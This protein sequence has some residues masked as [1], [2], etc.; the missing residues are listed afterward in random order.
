MQSETFVLVPS[1][2]HARYIE[3]CLRSIFDQ[4]LPPKKLLVIDD[5]S[6]DGSVDVIRRV[7]ADCP[8]AS[9]L[10]AR[11]NRGLCRTLNEGIAK[12][13]GEYF[14]YLGSDDRWMPG[15][16]AARTRLL[17][18]CRNAVL[19]YGNALLVDAEGDI[20]Y[21]TAD[22]NEVKYPDGNPSS[23]LFEGT[24]P[25]SSSVVYR[26]SALDDVSWDENARLEDYEMYLKL[27]TRGEFAFDPAV[28]SVWRLHGYN[29]SS[30]DAMMLDELIAA[31]RRN[32]EAIGAENIDRV[33]GR[34]R[35]RYARIALQHGNKRSALELAL[36]SR[37]YASAAE[38]VRFGARLMMPTAL[39]DLKRKHRKR[40]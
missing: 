6:S 21:S 38:L 24:A 32:T 4:T 2:N 13:S 7:L 39:A 5:G 40:S 35:F 28:L 18:E 15:M 14:A 1:Y 16:I 33:N 31:Q 25:I 8:F 22:Q 20:L 27:M 17:D 36:Q 29:T 9:E 30:D 12:S 3:E 26:R 11:E 23:M 19:A 34:T 10:I 37:R